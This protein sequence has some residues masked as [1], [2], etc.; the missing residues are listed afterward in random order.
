MKNWKKIIVLTILVLCALGCTVTVEST[1][2]GRWNTLDKA[3]H[4]VKHQEYVPRP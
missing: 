3:E 1:W 2:P 4:S